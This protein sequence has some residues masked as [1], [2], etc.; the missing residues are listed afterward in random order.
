MGVAI[1]ISEEFLPW[2][3]SAIKQVKDEFGVRRYR[4]IKDVVDDAV[5]RLI[6]EVGIK[7]NNYKK[8]VS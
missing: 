2:I 5:K 7:C 6:K 3:D 8:E 1:K 4:T